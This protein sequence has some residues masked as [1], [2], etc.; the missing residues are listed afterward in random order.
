[1]A[2]VSEGAFLSGHLGPFP[3]PARFGCRRALPSTQD[4]LWLPAAP[5]SPAGWVD[6]GYTTGNWSLLDKPK[7]VRDKPES[8]SCA[9]DRTVFEM[10]L[11]GL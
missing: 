8:P 11:G 9:V 10:W 6:W 4:Q 5:V 7:N 2:T 3:S 1:M